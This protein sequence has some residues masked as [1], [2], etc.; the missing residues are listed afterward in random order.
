MIR[1]PHGFLHA[2]SSGEGPPLLLLR[3][4]GG[5]IVLWG[6]FAARLA[7]HHRVLAFDP[8][9]IGRS[10]PARAMSTR[11]MAGDARA[12]LDHFAVDRAHVFG[13]SLGGMVATWLAADHGARIDRL[14]LAST[15]PWSA[16][17]RHVDVRSALS[18]AGC[19]RHPSCGP[20]VVRRML[21]PEFR[22]RHPAA[23]RGYER[24]MAREPMSRATM[25]LQLSAAARHNAKGALDA[26]KNPTLVLIGTRD[27]IA[28][29]ESQRWLAAALSAR[30]GTLDAGHDVTLERPR[31]TA[32]RV[33]AFLSGG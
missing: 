21:S 18:L 2:T 32:E 33:G 12:V 9:G 26:I 4:L 10:S 27:V 13:I 31:E 24:L 28:A 29:P 17:A 5:S 23:V 11:E 20:C 7:E 19:L 8:R 15:L 25:L 22:A 16:S 3:P 14:V 1:V 6:S 30:V